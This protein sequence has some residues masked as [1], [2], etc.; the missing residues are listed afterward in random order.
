ML[1][2][3]KYKLYCSWNFTGFFFFFHLEQGFSLSVLYKE[4]GDFVDFAMWNLQA[5]PVFS[6]ESEVS[7]S[8]TAAIKAE[9]FFLPSLFLSHMFLGNKLL[10][11]NVLYVL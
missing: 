4:I 9:V 11:A 1:V 6:K 7:V 2:A 3:Q 10:V 5:K 8:S